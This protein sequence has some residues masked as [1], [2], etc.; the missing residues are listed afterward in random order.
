MA[1]KQKID[2][3]VNRIS[4]ILKKSAKNAHSDEIISLKE[5]I[6]NECRFNNTALFLLTDY[7]SRGMREKYNNLMLKIIEDD[8]VNY[9]YLYN[10][11]GVDT[12]DPKF[13]LTYLD[14]LEK[15]NGRQY[16]LILSK[17]QVETIAEALL[18]K[19]QEV[20]DWDNAPY[21]SSVNNGYDPRMVFRGVQS[22]VNVSTWLRESGNG[23]LNTK[24]IEKF[25]KDKNVITTLRGDPWFKDYWQY[26]QSSGTVTK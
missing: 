3:I 23:S 16:K 6:L 22:L 11:I 24:F 20:F 12:I 7:L 8:Q 5:Q 13:V 2:S 15:I 19:H 14:F 26:L 9:D 18:T 4:E 25:I 1:S 10:G 21:Y 17:K